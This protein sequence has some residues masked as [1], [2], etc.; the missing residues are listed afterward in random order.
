MFLFPAGVL[1]VLTLAALAVDLT[2][3]HLGEREAISAATA[4]AND[5]AGFGVDV[6]RY[7]ATGEVVLDPAKVEQAAATGQP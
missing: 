2:V 6:A 4:A 1:V 3:V 5:A 7:R